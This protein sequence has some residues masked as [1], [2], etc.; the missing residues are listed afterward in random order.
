M[1]WTC[2]VSSVTVRISRLEKEIHVVQVAE[3]A[4]RCKKNKRGQ[5]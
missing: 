5:A 1:S 4:K 2:L 3:G